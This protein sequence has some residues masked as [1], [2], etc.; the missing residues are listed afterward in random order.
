[1]DYKFNIF[2]EGN[3]YKVELKNDFDRIV[4][5]GWKS[6]LFEA[7]LDAVVWHLKQS[8]GDARL[9]IR[10]LLKLDLKK[11]EETLQMEVLRQ[12]AGEKKEIYLR[13]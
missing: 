12:E 2:W 4:A 13:P 1:M 11:L 6:N 10:A 8:P 5:W 9:V 3:A 7:V